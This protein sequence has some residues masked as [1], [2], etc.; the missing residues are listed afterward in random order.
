[1][2]M[3]TEKEGEIVRT[4]QPIL[5]KINE[6]I[7]EYNTHQKYQSKIYE[8][9]I[10]EFKEDIKD[11]LN[12]LKNGAF[13]KLTNRFDILFEKLIDRFDKMDS[14]TTHAFTT[15]QATMSIT[16]EL[17]KQR[18]ELDKQKYQ[19]SFEL[20]KLSITNWFN[21]FTKLVTSGGVVY[22]LLDKFLSG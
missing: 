7:K 16:N 12:I 14:N 15:L 5:A 1:M 17:L 4:L 8:N 18:N 22:L 21:M 20:K 13:T 11:I 2:R 10:N 9:N 19:N 6:Q 3:G